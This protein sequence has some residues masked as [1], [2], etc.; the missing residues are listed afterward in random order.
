[1]DF[2]KSIFPDYYLDVVVGRKAMRFSTTGKYRSI[3]PPD[4]MLKMIPNN[5]R[6]LY[7]EIVNE[8]SVHD[9]DALNDAKNI[10]WQAVVCYAYMNTFI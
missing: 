10:Y 9:H 5:K 2:R 8:N 6:R 7:M 3:M 1:M 4:D